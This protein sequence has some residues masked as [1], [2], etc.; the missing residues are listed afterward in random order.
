MLT[1]LKKLFLVSVLCSVS[2][3]QAS[4]IV[5]RGQVHELSSL[6]TV[7]LEVNYLTKLVTSGQLFN[8]NNVLIAGLS[9][10]THTQRFANDPLAKEG[11]I[12]AVCLESMPNFRRMVAHFS[13]VLIDTGPA[14]KAAVLH[15]NY[16]LATI[17]CETEAG[18]PLR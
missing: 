2:A 5:C 7:N 18:N 17:H 12:K 16:R 8:R 13:V 1:L 10:C 14:L 3:A 15:D 9:D 11:S 6:Y 4:D